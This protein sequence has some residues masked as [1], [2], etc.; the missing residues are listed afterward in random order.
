MGYLLL[1]KR[2]MDIS[3]RLSGEQ[4][5]SWANQL[6][7]AHYGP[8]EYQPVPDKDRGDAGI[9]GFSLSGHAYQAYGPEDEPLATYERYE[10]HRTKLTTDI[11]KFIDNRVV[12]GQLFGKIQISRWILLVPLCDSKE[13]IKHANKKTQEVHDAKL[14][15]TTKDFRVMVQDEA[16]FSTERNLL[17]NARV[18]SIVIDGG[19]TSED[20]VMEWADKND[21]L[22]KVIDDKATRLKT[23][24]N[25]LSRATFRK[26]IIK[27]YLDG[28]NVLDELRKYPTAY[29][30]VRKI[31]SDKEKYLSLEIASLRD[32]NPQIL[33]K[34]LQEL[35]DLIGDIPGISNG[36]IDA[37]AWEAVS[38]WIIRCPLDFPSGG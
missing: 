15:Y 38:D 11:K 28:Q 14:P 17:L 21:Q 1:E 7:M 18:S 2:K 36:L 3:P 20:E 19:K 6:L 34:S 13:I 26:D 27:V 25:D 8:G 32:A 22:V 35:H 9:E 37:I 4:W 5:Q 30:A 24:P 10:R 16:S 31:K 33:R 23:L 12:L 29:E